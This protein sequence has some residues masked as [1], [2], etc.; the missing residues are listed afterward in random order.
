ML[1]YAKLPMVSQ[2]EGLLN[3]SI[4][5]LIYGYSKHIYELLQVFR[6]FNFV[7]DKQ[8]IIV[9]FYPALLKFNLL[10]YRTVR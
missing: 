6:Y 9:P 2:V 3:L 7:S 1:I 10:L 4:L 8:S 5:Y